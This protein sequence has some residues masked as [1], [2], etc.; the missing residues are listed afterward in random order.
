VDV[1]IINQTVPDDAADG[2]DAVDT[3]LLDGV[4]LDVQEAWICEDMM[5]VLQV[6]RLLS[7]VEGPR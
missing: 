6:S 2:P 5:F 1:R 4:S 3:R 7:I